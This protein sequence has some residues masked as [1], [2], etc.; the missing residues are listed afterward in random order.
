MISWWP[1]PTRSGICG[2]SQA[3]VLTVDDVASL[4]SVRNP[5]PDAVTLGPLVAA[6]NDSFDAAPKICTAIA[7][8]LSHSLT[9]SCEYWLRMPPSTSSVAPLRTTNA[10]C[11]FSVLKPSNHNL[12]VGPSTRNAPAGD[13]PFALRTNALTL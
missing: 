9:G 1:R 13:S 4:I 3:H 7:S 5:S 11:A 12:A 2:S 8:G 6:T 10:G